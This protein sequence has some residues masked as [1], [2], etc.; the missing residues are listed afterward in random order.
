M[1]KTADIQWIEAVG[2]YVKL[3]CDRTRPVPHLQ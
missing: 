3:H 1:I 2:N